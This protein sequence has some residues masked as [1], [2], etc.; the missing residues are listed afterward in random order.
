ML[1]VFNRFAGEDHSRKTQLRRPFRAHARYS[2][3]REFNT[4]QRAGKL[5]G[6]LKGN[7]KRIGKKAA[8][9]NAER[10]AARKPIAVVVVAAV[11]AMY[12]NEAHQEEPAKK[13]WPT[14]QKRH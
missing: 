6:V 13:H 9:G 3:D 1:V 4:R 2:N 8:Q 10:S 11:S 5:P 12:E 14:P 7:R